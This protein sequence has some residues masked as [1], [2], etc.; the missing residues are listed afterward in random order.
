MVKHVIQ[1][2]G[3]VRLSPDL[4]CHASSVY[5][6]PKDS[7]EKVKGAKRLIKPRNDETF[8]FRADTCRFHGLVRYRYP[9]RCIKKITYAPVSKLVD[10][11]TAD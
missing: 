11:G 1:T 8:F 10:C 7:F 5:P 9:C 6:V 3:P 2:P 4:Y